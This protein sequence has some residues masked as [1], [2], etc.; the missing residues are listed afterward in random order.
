MGHLEL[1]HWAVGGTPGWLLPLWSHKKL[2][3][4][5]RRGD[6]ACSPGSSVVKPCILLWGWSPPPPNQMGLGI[7]TVL[8]TTTSHLR[9][10]SGVWG[11]DRIATPAS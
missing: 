2:W 3:E 10:P 6:N 1:V 4:V 11:G 8:I 9:G 7:G 5:L